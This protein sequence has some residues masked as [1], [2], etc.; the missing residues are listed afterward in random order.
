MMVLLSFLEFADIETAAEDGA[1]TL[2]LILLADSAAH[3]ELAFAA[4]MA[5]LAGDEIP[6]ISTDIAPDAKGLRTAEAA[7]IDF[8]HGATSFQNFRIKNAGNDYFFLG[9]QRIRETIAP[10]KNTIPEQM[11]AVWKN[12]INSQSILQ[13][14]IRKYPSQILKALNRTTATRTKYDF[15]LMHSNPRFL[16]KGHTIPNNYF[17]LCNYGS[18]SFQYRNHRINR[19]DFLPFPVDNHA[20]KD[21]IP[22]IPS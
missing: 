22:C 19:K 7:G 11:M 5:D 8:L 16:H 4:I 6:A 1:R 21:R 15:Q 9:R 12:W 3:G 13:V 17:S 20:C 2:F 18:G 10:E 14:P